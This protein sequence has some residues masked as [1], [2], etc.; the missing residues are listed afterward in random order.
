MRRP[1]PQNVADDIAS[2]RERIFS[3]TPVSRETSERLDRFVELVLRWQKT[4][5]LI[6]PSTIPK[7]WTRHVADSLQLLEFVPGAKLWV[8][9]GSGGGFPGIVLAS[10]LAETP[11]ARVHLVESNQKKAALLR[12]ALRATGAPGV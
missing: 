10:A 1:K 9:L 7:I 3:L 6:A 12:E 8:D 2:D 11:G 4:T 5:N